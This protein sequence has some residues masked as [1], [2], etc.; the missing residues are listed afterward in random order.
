M[1]TI[2]DG[3]GGTVTPILILGWSDERAASNLIHDLIGVP[4]PDVSLHPARTRSGEIS[5]L[6][7]D[8]ATAVPAVEILSAPAVFT[9]EHS[10]LPGASMTFVV[11]GAIGLELDQETLIRVVLRVPFREVAA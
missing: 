8:Y 1:S 4:A 7:D 5:L 3:A 6:L 9:L 2:S 11:A 10:E